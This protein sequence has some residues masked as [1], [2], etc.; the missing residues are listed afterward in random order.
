[1]IVHRN[2]ARKLLY[3]RVIVG[4][5]VGGMALVKELSRYRHPRNI[6]IID[7]KK[8]FERLKEQFGNANVDTLRSP[9]AA[10]IIPA[11]ELKQYDQWFYSY[12]GETPTVKGFLQ[13]HERLGITY[14]DQRIEGKVTSI[15]I[16]GRWGLTRRPF[17]AVKFVSS[18]G[19]EETVLAKRVALCTGNQTPRIPD[20]AKQFFDTVGNSIDERVKHVPETN[21]WNNDYASKILR[22]NNQKTTVAVVGAGETAG[23]ILLGLL[24][25]DP[26]KSL[27]EEGKLE[28]KWIHK[29]T[30]Q[31]SPFGPE[32]G[33]EWQ[34]KNPIY[35]QFFLSLDKEK[36][37]KILQKVRFGGGSMK[38][39]TANKLEQ[40]RDLINIQAEVGILQ[41]RSG[42]LAFGFPDGSREEADLVLLATGYSPK[43]ELLNQIQEQTKNTPKANAPFGLL[44]NLCVPGTRSTISV[45]GSLTAVLTGPFAQNI[46]G[47]INQAKIIAND[48]PAWIAQLKFHYK[49][50]LLMIGR[51]I[52]LD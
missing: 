37:N 11:Q 2:N 14:Q 34:P 49:R 21:I 5:G 3:E 30:V 24:E 46:R 19:I 12:R 18:A 41:E 17:W 4:N 8:P 7:P 47:L 23:R 48:E 42:K 45:S 51:R 28:I 52:K 29:R 20:F 44:H 1:M 40:N 36:R 13:I 22:S 10:S 6:V 9:Y 43:N 16:A 50:M 35:K 15:V 38:L 27:L 26:W 33:T 31:K 39:E 25:R 32:V